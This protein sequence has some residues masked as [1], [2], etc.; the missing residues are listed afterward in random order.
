ML[1][2]IGI[3]KIWTCTHLQNGNEPENARNKN[4]FRI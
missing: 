2:D 3:E 1:E 4:I